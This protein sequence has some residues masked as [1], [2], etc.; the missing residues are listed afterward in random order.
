MKSWL[1]LLAPLFWEVAPQA[2][3]STIFAHKA[4]ASMHHKEGCKVRTEEDADWKCHSSA[5]RCFLWF[6]RLFYL[7]SM[8]HFSGV[9]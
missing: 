9:T 8:F 6:E 5:A 3:G 4:I 7:K 2:L 1:W